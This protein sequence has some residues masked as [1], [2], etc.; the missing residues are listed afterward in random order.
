MPE[1]TIIDEH[2]KFLRSEIDYLRKR[3]EEWAQRKAEQMEGIAETLTRVR[4]EKQMT[5]VAGRRIAW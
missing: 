5:G 1:V 2:L 4:R 3:S